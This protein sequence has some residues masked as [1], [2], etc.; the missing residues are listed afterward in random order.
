MA[1]ILLDCQGQSCPQPVLECKRCIEDN[2]PDSFS[3]LVDNDAARENVSRFASTKGYRSE[4]QK[5]ESGL[6]R[7]TLSKASPAAPAETAPCETT[8]EEQHGRPCRHTEQICVFICSRTLGRGDET[9][10]AKLMVNFVSTLPEL[11][12]DLWR[13]IMVNEGVTLAT[14]GSPVLET[15]HG[16]EASGVSILV[17]GTCLDHFQ[18]LEQKQV[19]QTTNMLDV[20]T[21]LQL[22]TKVIRP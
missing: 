4:A 14:T 21:S 20:V 2:T 5:L 19:G 12:Q 3:V 1:E 22:A 17:C 15:L 16:L 18:L 6:W 7:L 10:G 9:L 13:I 11:G 8:S